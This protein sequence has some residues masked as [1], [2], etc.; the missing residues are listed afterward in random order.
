LCRGFKFDTTNAIDQCM[1]PGLFDEQEKRPGIESRG[2]TQMAK[3]GSAPLTN[4]TIAA[5]SV[6]AS[7]GILPAV[8]RTINTIAAVLARITTPAW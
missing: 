7:R 5:T 2:D 4:T 1:E 3:P 6:V 8:R